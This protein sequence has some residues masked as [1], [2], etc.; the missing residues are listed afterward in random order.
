MLLKALLKPKHFVSRDGHVGELF[1]SNHGDR[2]VGELLVLDP[3]GLVA[4]ASEVNGDAE[5]ADRLPEFLQ[6]RQA[7][8][9]YVLNQ[10]ILH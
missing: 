6:R 5:I 4:T 9:V 8:R 7:D 3:T 2:L 10:S 1:V